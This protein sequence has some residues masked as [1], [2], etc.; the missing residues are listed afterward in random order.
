MDNKKPTW[1]IFDVGGVLLDWFGSSKVFAANIG[2]P[3]VEM[4]QLFNE[5]YNGSTLDSLMHRGRISPQEAWN[6]ALE[7][8]NKSID[9]EEVIAAWCADPYWIQDSLK[10]LD[11]LENNGYKISI[12]S[13]SWFSFN[14]PARARLFPAQF[15]RYEHVFDSGELGYM[16]PD[17][18]IYEIVETTLAVAPLELLFIDDNRENLD[19]AKT[20]GWNVRY[21]ESRKGDS[22][23]QESI[24]AV[25]SVLLA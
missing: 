15:S 16:K 9:I 17:Q 18:K 25:R 8:Y 21:F 6:I 12:L 23:I 19:A 13:N 5:P 24:A 20:R 2:I 3:H 4:L 11:D 7:P 22:G 1:I 10:L 14:S